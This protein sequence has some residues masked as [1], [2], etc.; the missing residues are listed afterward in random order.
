[1]S[2]AGLHLLAQYLPFELGDDGQHAGHGGPG[3]LRRKTRNQVRD[4]L[5]LA[6]SRRA[7][8]YSALVCHDRGDGRAF[9]TFCRRAS[10]I[11]DIG[12][13]RVGSG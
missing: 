11:W 1:L 12:R 3:R 9:S 2:D 4:G 8:D 6:R 10:E 7:M 13:T 5:A